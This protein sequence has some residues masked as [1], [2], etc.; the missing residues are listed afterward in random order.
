MGA[1]RRLCAALI[2]LTAAGAAGCASTST[3]V[4]ANQPARTARADAPPQEVPAEPGQAFLAGYKAF[5]S[6]DFAF[7]AESLDFAADRDSDLADYALYYLGLTD[8]A[9]NRDAEAE[10]ALRRLVDTYPQSVW[11]EHAEL[12]IAAIEIKTGRPADASALA[13]R[14]VG[15]TANHEVEQD[16]RLTLAQALESL[17][18]PRG[19]YEQLETIRNRYPHGEADSRARAQERSLLAAHPEIVD[20]NTLDYRRAEA[21]L[22][23]TEGQADGALAQIDAALLL[24]PSPVMLAELKWIEARA[25]LHRDPSRAKSAMMSYLAVAPRGPDAPAVLD[26][27]A[28]M[29]WT[30]NDTDQARDWFRRLVRQFPESRQAPDAMFAIGRTFEDDGDL[31][32]ARAQYERTYAR[33]PGSEIAAESRF[34]AAFTLYMGGEYQS[35]ARRFGAI[36]P[37]LADGSQ[38]DMTLYWRARA[39]EK[40]GDNEPARAIYQRLAISIDSNYYPALAAAR[41]GIRPPVFPAALV[42]EPSGEPPSTLAGDA[43]F[44]LARVLALRT[45][46]LKPLEPAELKALEEHAQEIPALRGFVL[47]AYQD[48]DAWHDALAASV[49]MEQRGEISREL[50]ERL[51]YPRA[52][53]DLIDSAARERG[54]DPYLLLALT[55]QES[56]FD[57]A[58]RSSS[59]ARGLMQLMAAT[60]QRVSGTPREES[61]NL[62]DPATSVQ[63][64]SSYLKQLFEMY[65]GDQFRAVAAYNA[66]EHAVANWNSKFPGDDDQW[67]ENIGYHETRDYV[68]KVIGGLREYQLIY[69]TPPGAPA[70]DK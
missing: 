40:S 44:H 54:L 47:A 36:D 17:G 33:Y 42:A 43:A 57:P 32:S 55:R 20:V 29:A 10:S 27:L 60:A 69:A 49:R 61:L 63:L 53:W 12:V 41:V 2:L 8:E 4:P 11:V 24:A 35:A 23:L 70:L 18:D 16:A 50:A 28:R 51:R 64:G 21:G 59:D 25:A 22:L 9:L 58:A 56:L 52:Y 68:K 6:G 39:L 46:E 67:V 14:I 30:A 65:D 13:S 1:N 15:G 66:G 3:T 26:K 7:A 5:R 38:R 48:A 31:E 62:Y 19:A 45:L 34:R 37:R